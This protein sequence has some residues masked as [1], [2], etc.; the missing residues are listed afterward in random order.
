[1]LKNDSTRLE[2]TSS[3]TNIDTNC[4]LAAWAHLDPW[5]ARCVVLA[6]TA[7]PREGFAM[8]VVC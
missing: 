5:A 7:L 1:M 6:I 8:P 3:P 4:S 2:K